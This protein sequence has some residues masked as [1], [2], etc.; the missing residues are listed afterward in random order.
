MRLIFLVFIFLSFSVNA[1]PPC[2]G[3]GSSAQSAISVCGSGVFPQPI[4]PSCT[5]VTLPPVPGACPD[6]I[7]TDNAVWYRFRIYQTGTLGFLI[8]PNMASDDYDWQLMNITGRNPQDV[9]TTNLAVSYNL[10]ATTGATGCVPA[11]I[12]D[13]N[14]AGTSAS[15]FNRLL[16]V[17][18]GQE[19]LLMVNNFSNS[20]AG[21]NL[22][23]TGGTAVVTN[24]VAPTITSVTTAGCNSSQLKVTFS[25][26]ILCS[27]ITST[28]SEFSIAGATITGVTSLCT[29]GTNAVNT[30]FI[31]LQNPLP[32]GPYNL[33]VGNGTDGNIF[34]DVCNDPLVAAVFPF[35]ALLQ[36]S[37]IV[38]QITQNSCT[39]TIL[40]IALNKKIKCSSVSGSGF[41]FSVS[42]GVNPI[43]SIALN[44]TTDAVPLTDT[45]II[46]LAT[47]LTQGGYTLNINNGSDGNTIVDTCSL[48]TAVGY[49]F[50]FTVPV[51]P[52]APVVTPTVTYCL[53]ATAAQLTA[54]GTNLLWY[55]AATGGTGSTTAP[56]PNTGTA[57]TFNFY[58]S[59][60]NGT[61]EGPRSLIAVAVLSTIPVPTV[62]TPI[63]KC[64]FSTAS[65][66]TATGTGLLWYPTLVGGTSSAT[67]P[68]PPTN[69]TGSFVYYVTQTI[70]GCESPRVA[71][72]V[73][74]SAT[75]LPP[76]VVSPISICQGI[77]A[78]PLTAVGTN[79][80]WY[81]A[82][83]GGVGSATAP[84][85]PTAALAT[86]T[87]YVSQTV[88]G[89]ESPRD[90]IIVTVD[91]VPAAPT[92]P[93]T[94][95]SYCLNAP[96]TP[97]VATGVGIRWFTVPTGGGTGTSVT[98][99]P[100][101]SAIGTTTYYV[102]QTNGSCPGPRVAIVVT[103]TS[104]LA[105]LTVTSPI[106]VCQFAPAPTINIS[107]AAGA[108]LVWYTTGVGGVG[109]ATTP[110]INSNVVSNTTYYVTQTNGSCEANPRAALVVNVT[111]TPI[112]PTVIS[113]IT[114][115][116][117]ATAT[118]L[119][120][121]G[122]NL[123][124]Y[125][126]NIGGTG[127]ATAPTPLTTSTGNTNYYVSQSLNSCESPRTMIAVAVNPAPTT[128]PT[129]TSPVNYCVGNTTV[130]LVAAGT[131]L[132]WFLNSSG[133]IGNNATP[134][135]SSATAGTTTYYVAQS[136][137]ACQGPR[138]PIVV[139]VLAYPAAPI[140]VSPLVLC[141]GSTALPLAALGTN[142]LWYANPIG[143]VGST[144]AP[145]PSTASLGSTTYYVS[146]SN[147]NCEGPRVAMIVTIANPLAVSIG[148]DVT[149]CEGS[150]KQF[151]PTVTPP[152]A[153]YEWRPL[154]TTP[155]ATIN[156]INNLDAIVSP[157]NNA[158]YI[159]KA[160]IGSCVRED[161]V[162]VNVLWKP[163]VNADTDKAIC[164][165]DSALLIGSVTHTTG[166][167]LSY[168]WTPAATLRT[169]TL[170]QTYAIPTSTTDYTLTVKTDIATYGCDFTS[171]DIVRVTIQ[172]PI[173]AFAGNDTIAVK[174]VPHQ[175]YGS[176]GLNYVWSSPSASVLSPFVKNT[177]AIIN[178]D[179]VFYLKVTDGVGCAGFDTVF[180]KVYEGPKYYI[181]NAFTPNGDGNNDVF[182][183]I[184]VGMAN[185]V[186]FR[187]YNRYGELIFE[188]NK[189][190]KGWDGTYKGKDQPNGVYIW[191]IS[192]TD[193]NFNK[194][195][196]QG[197]VN[198]IR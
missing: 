147:G 72:V 58:V 31:N 142:L 36:V 42:P 85:P 57:G 197:T 119:T 70:S 167:I 30:L 96:A 86:L 166:P 5:G 18:A 196:E 184:P 75:P 23:F 87:Y 73:V 115:C 138:E 92:V 185:T 74:I 44:C 113:P 7:I 164:L 83:T 89:C 175:L 186:Y 163:I 103:V 95:I 160:N 161:T 112:A 144:T 188:T 128:A 51:S 146:Q 6:N 136:I 35:N 64:Q 116:Q 130:P 193:R 24:N 150:T 21:Y 181:P 11:G 170:I 194:V 84:T 137:G 56:T 66:L 178:N 145:T 16:P 158:T 168:D 33:N 97:L 32:T 41:E 109:S 179:A 34:N 62:V 17:L 71:L 108:T 77:P 102:S 141:P 93:N 140:V 173:K 171:T 180:V 13:F 117:N 134:T 105:A 131:N 107:P 82:F 9:Y 110:I 139:N 126:N 192:G 151:T 189:W 143:G 49:T 47:P 54:T 135:P 20:G 90:D 129:V 48:S 37:P 52:A 27:S 38:T 39:P 80:L 88:A 159:L 78:A 127:T 121:S 133:G 12:L 153:T 104:S 169:P 1:Q 45:I 111:A 26:D 55:T 81:N 67:A 172:A 152:G 190:L 61:C 132:L 2:S 79:L 100:L 165:S 106:N 63:T 76:T 176:G 156:G 25:E 60:S 69:T 120:A 10:S 124:W 118:A 174:G 155:A 46:T 101:T 182:R 50:S 195:N 148:A 28:G 94:A 68:T 43:S 3:P 59:Q 123:L 125:A 114:Y 19:Y 99:V 198:L 4:L 157:V 22:S 162:N 53:N 40:K 91:A 15:R 65:A 154:G 177:K 149:I 187:V 191:M 122:T 8:S 98:P 29:A 14:C 183:A